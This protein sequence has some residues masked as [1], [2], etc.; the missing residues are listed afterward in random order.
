MD[1]RRARASFWLDR[2][3][4]FGSLPT[5]TD[6][7]RLKKAI[8][9]L[10]M[11]TGAFVV[12]PLWIMAYYAL[13]VPAAAVLPLTFTWVS[14]IGLAYIDVTK[15]VGP[16]PY[17][18]AG[19]NLFCVAAMHVALGGFSGSSAILLFALFS[20]L[21]VL[22]CVGRK[23]ALPWLGLV[24]VVLLVA[25]LADPALARSAPQIPR[26]I[27]TAFYVANLTGFCLLFFFM[28]RYFV[29][30]R[31]RAQARSQ[32]LLLN[33]LPRAIA[34]RLQ[35]GPGVIADRFEE[36]SILFADIDGFTPLSANASPEEMVTWLNGIYSKFDS[37]VNKHQVEKIRTIGDNYMVAAGAPNPRPDHA[38]VLA[39]LAFDLCEYIQACPPINGHKVAFRLGI[40]SGPVIGGIIGRQKFQYDLWGDTVNVASR[41]ESSGQPGRIQ[42]SRATYE[43]LCHRFEC[44]PRGTI[45]VKGKGEM[46]TWFL[47][48]E[49]A[50]A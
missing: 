37:L 40:H 33:V 5:D 15:R 43:R 42:I 28:I 32:Q 17:I 2:A 38:E 25:G 39:R 3:A 12:E 44:T 26:S 7:V 45:E 4:E 30:E 23:Q 14:L 36:V 11:G 9:V 31:D 47:V 19:H 16:F 34:E 41:M 21:G 49:M 50:P 13:H 24:V 6:E 10:L 22:L 8:L 29:V 48:S 27:A 1:Q 18:L 46:E 35:W 20:P